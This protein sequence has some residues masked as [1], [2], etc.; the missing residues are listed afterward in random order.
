MGDS[1]FV[2]T[3]GAYFGLAV[4]GVLYN[5]HAVKAP[6]SDKQGPVYHSDL[7]SMIGECNTISPYGVPPDLTARIGIRATRCC[8][9][10][11]TCFL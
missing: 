1:I 10:E 11:S 9:I 4:S 8:S 6:A 7:F 3:F 5:K 2:H